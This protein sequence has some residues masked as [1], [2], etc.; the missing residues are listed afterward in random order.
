VSLIGITQLTTLIYRAEIVRW[1]S[2]SMRPF[3]IVE[4][5]GFQSL[6]KTGRPECYIPSR[7]TVSRDVK[8]VFANTRKRVAKML[9]V[10]I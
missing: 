9:R 8:Q 10:I 3:N 4:D 2:E 6:M 1:V 7:K 5:R